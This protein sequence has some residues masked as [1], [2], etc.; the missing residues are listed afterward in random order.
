MKKISLA[1]YFSIVGVCLALTAC[2][3]KAKEQPAEIVAP[4]IIP[5]T[6]LMSLAEN[7][8]VDDTPIMVSNPTKEEVYAM[9]EAT[10]EGMSE[11]ETARL[12]ENIKGA[13]LQFESAYLYDNIFDKLS[14]KDSLTW[15]YFD[16][17]GDIQIGWAYNESFAEM[18]AIMEA[19]ELSENEF[20]EKYGDPVMTY[21]R[22]DATNFINLLK[23]MQ[24]SVHHE[25]LVADLQQ[26]ID[27]TYLAAETHEMEYANSIYKILHDLDYYLLRYGLEDVGKYTSDDNIVA[28]YYGVLN[29]YG[30]TPLISAADSKYHIL[31]ARQVESDDAK[32]GSITPEHEDFVDPD[33]RVYF[34]YDLE[35]F[36][37]NDSY[38]EVLNETLQ[39]Y[40]DSIRESYR[41]D[42]KA[43]IGP[44]P[45]DHKPPYDSLI[46]QYFTYVG[47]DYVSLVYNN[48]TYMGGAHPYSAFEGITID[49][50]TGE[51]VSVNRFI[52]DS[53]EYIGGQLT[54][55]L[56]LA[57]YDA[58]EW[59]YYLNENSVVFFY[60]AP[61]I[62]DFVA[63]KRLR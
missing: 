47:D 16:Q 59:G 21:N 11:E 54:N 60:Y 45:E 22:F 4:N 58:N 63:T 61:Q 26:L 50:A 57:Q 41:H 42:A 19:E 29:V 18:R 55:V 38:P 10:L 52:D 53:D 24:N 43:Y 33:D 28:K 14:K 48:V 13:N 40:Y 20:Y 17:K 49:C 25:L 5:E 44:L 27:L 23:E 3:T 12:T 46:F 32:Y 2:G 30:E 35:C 7:D 6:V 9:R 36:Y 56:G 31:W 34:Y 1:F 15:N 51:V 37:F 39:K 8:T 62:W